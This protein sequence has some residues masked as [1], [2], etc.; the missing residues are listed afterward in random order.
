MHS[1]SLLEQHCRVGL[2]RVLP[3]IIFIL[4]ALGA[5]SLLCGWDLKADRQALRDAVESGALPSSIMDGKQ[6]VCFYSMV[7]PYCEKNAERLE[8]SRAK[9]GH[10]DT[11]LTVVF[12][13]PSEPRDPSLFFDKCGL[14]YDGLVYLD[15]D[16]FLDVVC[17]RWP[18]V[19]VLKDG[20]IIR[21]M[22]YRGL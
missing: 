15:Q 8:R 20:R 19:L 12:G 9:S 18:L 16:I 6:I 1:G 3:G 13:R 7:C 5:A 21:K 11:P 2:S 14:E 17:G 4:L 22:T 10:N